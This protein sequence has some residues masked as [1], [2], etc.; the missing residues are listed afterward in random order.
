MNNSIS[1]VSSFIILCLFTLRKDFYFETFFN[2]QFIAC[3]LLTFLL[4]ILLTCAKNFPAQTREILLFICHTSYICLLISV[5]RDLIKFT[6]GIIFY[7]GFI[8]TVLCA[9]ISGA[10]LT[11]GLIDIINIKLSKYD[12]WK[13]KINKENYNNLASRLRV[14]ELKNFFDTYIKNYIYHLFEFLFRAL[15]DI[16]K[17]LS[18]N[19]YSSRVRRNFYNKL[20]NLIFNKIYEQCFTAIYPNT[21]DIVELLSNDSNNDTPSMIESLHM[22]HESDKQFYLNSNKNSVLEN[23]NKNTLINKDINMFSRDNLEN[24]DDINEMHEEDTHVDDLDEIDTNLDEVDEN[25]SHEYNKITETNNNSPNV[26]VMNSY[27]EDDNIYV[28]NEDKTKED[29]KAALR[30]KIAEKRAMRTGRDT[31]GSYNSRNSISTK[32]TINPDAFQSILKSPMMGQMMDVLMKDDN[33]EK[34]MK[35]MPKMTGNQMDMPKID[36][37]VMKQM[38]QVMTK[39]N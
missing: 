28:Q 23:S 12:F 17:Q 8:N 16:N 27:I 20:T 19:K 15:L 25:N 9:Y 26:S 38:L 4:T 10:F 14:N 36:P 35:Q 5:L 11:S 39:N 37:S 2:L 3:N 34:I 32:K 18:N 6:Y 13:K 7:Y 24:I 22:N 21:L 33:L 31:S 29:K 30:K 1:S